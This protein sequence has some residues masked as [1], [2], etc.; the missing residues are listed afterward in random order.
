MTGPRTR[1]V[2]LVSTLRRT[3]PTSQ[4]LNI[5]RGLDREAFEP[6]VVTLSAEPSGS[7]QTSFV[8]HGLPVKSLSMSRIRGVLNRRWR[9]DLERMSGR[10][11]EECVLHSQGIRADVISSQALSG[12]PRL[13][14]ARNY[15]YDDYVM[16]YGGILGGWMA[17]R[18]LHAL[19]SLPLVVACSTTLASQ[20]RPHRIETTV[21]RNGVDTTQFKPPTLEERV[22]ARAALGIAP[23]ARVGLSLGSLVS[24]KDPLSVIQAVRTLADP[25]FVM[26]LVGGGALEEECRRAAHDDERIRLTGHVA[27]VLCYLQ[28]ADFLVSASRSEGLPNSGLEALACGL[29]LVLS[30]IEPH[31]EL[32]EVA[33]SAGVLFPIGDV[34]ALADALRTVTSSNAAVSG[35]A[36][37]RATALIGAE[38]V[39]RRYQALYRQLLDVVRRP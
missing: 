39:S 29:P 20:L 26:L 1:V 4:L 28:A 33:P 7:M 9:D 22:R 36:P 10:R 27:D 25:G 16:K 31:R 12:V 35:L 30:A 14:T 11:L 8:Q 34:A 18:H 24:R 17:R 13:A 21:I 5:A 19:R 32:L 15:P 3:G 6:L 37:G 2:F 38:Q 23:G